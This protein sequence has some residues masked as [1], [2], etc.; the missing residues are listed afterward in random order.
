MTVVKRPLPK[1]SGFNFTQLVAY[2]SISLLKFLSV[3]TAILKVKGRELFRFV[4]FFSCSHPFN[5]RLITYRIH[6]TQKVFPV[7]SAL[8]VSKPFLLVS[9]PPRTFKRSLRNEALLTETL[10]LR[11]P[12]YGLRRRE[13]TVREFGMDM[14]TLLYLK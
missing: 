1:T 10:R 2:I 13:G 4:L 14:C 9:G 6:P 8:L 3:S 7:S 12:T 11:E 5:L